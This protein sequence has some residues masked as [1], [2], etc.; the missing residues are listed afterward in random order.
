MLGFTQSHLWSFFIAAFTILLARGVM[1]GLIN[2]Y[3]EDARGLEE[4]KQAAKLRGLM[5][6]YDSLMFKIVLPILAVFV[7]YQIT[8]NQPISPSLGVESLKL[9]AK[10]N[11]PNSEAKVIELNVIAEEQPREERKSKVKKDK[12]SNKAAFDKFMENEE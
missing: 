3:S 12:E 4:E 6:T 2:E 7:L 1:L 9:E 11:V 8:F 5:L 10:A